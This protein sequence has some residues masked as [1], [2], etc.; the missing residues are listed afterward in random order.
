MRVR[1]ICNWNL[2]HEGPIVMG[3]VEMDTAPG[4]THGMCNPCWEVSM[5]EIRKRREQQAW[6]KLTDALESK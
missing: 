2:T 6:Q 4:V 5:R 1:R 3:Y